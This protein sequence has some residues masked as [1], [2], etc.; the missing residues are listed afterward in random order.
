M[1]RATV[2]VEVANRSQFDFEP[3]LRKLEYTEDVYGDLEVART[4]VRAARLI[5]PGI[6]AELKKGEA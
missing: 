5:H 3:S 6:D 2:I 4:L 1:K